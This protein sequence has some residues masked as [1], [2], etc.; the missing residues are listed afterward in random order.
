MSNLHTE[1]TQAKKDILLLQLDVKKL[2][3]LV[4]E[5]MRSFASEIVKIN[6]CIGRENGLEGVPVDEPKSRES[7]PAAEN[8]SPLERRIAEEIEA[9]RSFEESMHEIDR[10]RANPMKKPFPEAYHPT[11][12]EREAFDEE[13]ARMSTEIRTLWWD[14]R[15]KLSHEDRVEYDKRAM[16]SA[17]L[18]KQM[19]E[20]IIPLRPIQQFK[21]KEE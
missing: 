11:R 19:R 15:L 13:I 21:P 14:R 8:A 18:I 5:F 20:G 12:E 4:E 6:A 9:R 7:D 3:T 1:S 2:K 17:L 10:L 16:K